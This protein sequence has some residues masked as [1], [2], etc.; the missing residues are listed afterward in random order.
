MP[1]ATTFQA[2]IRS[3][4]STDDRSF[5]VTPEPPSTSSCTASSGSTIWLKKGFFMPIDLDS[6]SFQFHVFYSELGPQKHYQFIL[7]ISRV[8]IRKLVEELREGPIISAQ[9]AIEV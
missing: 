6:F 8:E 4:S 2:P 7:A 3:S 9:A 5:R 1:G